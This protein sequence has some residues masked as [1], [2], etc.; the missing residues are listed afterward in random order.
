V[1]AGSGWTQYVAA[2]SIG[3]GF[4]Q[5][6]STSTLTFTPGFAYD[7]IEVY[8]VINPSIGSFTTN[9]GGSSLG[10][11]NC[12]GTAAA[13]EVTYSVTLSSNPVNIVPTSSTVV[14]IAGIVCWN[15]TIPG[16]LILVN[17]GEGNGV[18]SDFTA[19]TGWG[20][21][22]FI[23]KFAPNLTILNLLI[24]DTRSATGATTPASAYQTAL[25]SFI[26]YLQGISSDVYMVT[27]VPPGDST[28]ITNS[29]SYL[30]DYKAAATNENVPLLDVSTLMPSYTLQNS[31]SLRF[32][33]LHPNAGGYQY[34]T[35]LLAQAIWRIISP[36]GSA[37]VT[38]TT[39]SGSSAGSA[40][41][42]EPAQ[43][44]YDKK[45]VIQLGST[46]S[47]TATYTLPTAF[48][49]TPVIVNS[50]AAVTTNGTGT[51]VVTG[52]GTLP[53]TVI[54]EGY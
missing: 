54:L 14:Y 12:A 15:S 16:S 28:Y 7:H 52:T 43:R 18:I 33:T 39:V 2:A 9:N 8:Y 22:P 5:S 35:S 30:P 37:V 27:P 23:T 25:Q 6:S 10:T 42:S 32:D 48:L 11:T 19:S 44:P 46:L 20:T 21:E 4:M 53:R 29:A 45:V 38:Q 3:G 31:L 17:A 13:G 34:Y 41:F 26:T 36:T 49:N 50:D 51:V 47:G 1:T 40:T 24:N